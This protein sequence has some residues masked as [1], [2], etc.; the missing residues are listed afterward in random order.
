MEIEPRNKAIVLL[1][2]DDELFIR[3][4]FREYF[5]DYDYRVMEDE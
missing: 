5:E 1:T 4:S 3:D 2:I